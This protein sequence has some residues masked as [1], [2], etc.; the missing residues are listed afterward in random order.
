MTPQ[1][2]KALFDVL[3]RIAIAL[4][5]K[6]KDIAADIV[7]R[8]A[9]T[10]R[11]IEDLTKKEVSVLPEKYYPLIDIVKNRHAEIAGEILSIYPKK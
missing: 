11:M 2:F 7:N 10:Y 5:G 9:E 6:D 1:D 8:F 4:E 3:N